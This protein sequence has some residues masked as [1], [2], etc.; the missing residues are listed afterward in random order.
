[1]CVSRGTNEARQIMLKLRSTGLSNYSVL[2]GRQHPPEVA[3]GWRGLA[4]CALRSRRDVR[5]SPAA[6]IPA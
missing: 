6:S 5:L 3:V 2:E 1:L 4:P